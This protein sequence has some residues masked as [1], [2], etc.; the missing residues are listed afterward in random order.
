MLEDVSSLLPAAVGEESAVAHPA[1]G[2]PER[3]APLSCQVVGAFWEVCALLLSQAPGLHLVATC[4]CSSLWEAAADSNEAIA[5]ADATAT[6]SFLF[7]V[8]PQRVKPLDLDSSLALI[9]LHSE[10][11]MTSELASV[12]QV[13]VGGRVVLRLSFSLSS[14]R[15]F[16]AS[17]DAAWGR[18]GSVARI[19]FLPV[20]PSDLP[21][22]AS[23]MRGSSVGPE[24]HGTSP[25]DLPDDRRR[26]P[27]QRHSPP[28]SESVGRRSSWLRRRGGR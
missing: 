7:D 17:P 9:Q 28:P 8:R 16:T 21:L 4:T 23:G 11:D 24:A 13:S 26:N 18:N 6:A 20:T 25:A 1:A 5:V 12:A 10:L 2:A 14:S 27:L 3:I 15:V 19:S 22:S